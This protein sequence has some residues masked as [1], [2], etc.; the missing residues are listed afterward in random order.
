MIVPPTTFE[1]FLL[2]NQQKIFNNSEPVYKQQVDYKNN[3]IIFPE[4]IN[5]QEWFDIHLK[6]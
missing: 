1:L 4:D 3:I 2:K 5:I 6:L